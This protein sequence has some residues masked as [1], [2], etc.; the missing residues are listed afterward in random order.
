LDLNNKTIT[1][2]KS[3]LRSISLPSLR[4][5]LTLIIEAIVFYLFGYRKK[6]S[7]LVFLI[8]NLF[9]LGFLN[10]LLS[11]DSNPVNSYIVFNLILLEILVFIIEM[12]TFLI[13]V[14]EHGRLL[15]FLYVIV[16]NA[17]SLFAGGYLITHLPV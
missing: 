16:A 10:I 7:W 8:V 5:I 2:G 14:K 17:A 9:T 4:I 15:A 13:F 11:V 12:V 6:K 3:L 1:P